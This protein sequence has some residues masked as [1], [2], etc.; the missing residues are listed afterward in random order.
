MGN[1]AQRDILVEVAVG[2]LVKSCADLTADEVLR[3]RAWL[4]TALPT[5]PGYFAGQKERLAGYYPHGKKPW[6]QLWLEEA[7]G[8]KNG[9]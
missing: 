2:C 8:E 6:Y 7:L 1:D 9:K 4:E 3:C 5:L